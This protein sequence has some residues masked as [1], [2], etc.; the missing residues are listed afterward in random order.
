MTVIYA[1]EAW[2]LA[3]MGWGWLSVQDMGGRSLLGAHVF[4]GLLGLSSSNLVIT[5]LSP[6]SSASR[7][8]YFAAV[9]I[10]FLF[11]AVCVLD[12]LYTPQMGPVAFQSPTQNPACTLAKS[13]QLFFFSSTALFVGQA[14]ATMGYLIVQLLVS[15]AGLLDANQH[16]LWPGA[17]WG[18]GL[19][20]LLC[21]RLFVMFDGTAKGLA[22]RRTR[23][24]Q[25]FS[26]PIVEVASVFA[27]LMCIL[28]VFVGIEGVM[29]QRLSWRKAARYVSFFFSMSSAI[30]AFSLLM[31]RGL[32]TPGLLIHILVTAGVNVAG[33]LAAVFAR[34][35]P[36]NT[37]GTSDHPGPS[38]P[39]AQAVFNRVPQWQWNPPFP[40]GQPTRPQWGDP[41]APPADAVY[42]PKMAGRM[43]QAART[44]N[45]IPAPVEMMGLAVEK[46]K[47]V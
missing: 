40:P 14:G 30:V 32:L 45:P 31:G 7:S 2:I 22:D 3:I 9:L 21:F 41:S 36:D 16:T 6:K 8:A 1:V 42:G 35:Q 46:N 19:G 18:L 33:L 26:L 4:Y 15:G 12:T 29:F 43:M 47:G 28:G 37:A 13:Q 39:P 23:Y 10:L 11:T 17:A 34:A 44:R 38:A 5:A 27:T 20:M 25:L 24:V